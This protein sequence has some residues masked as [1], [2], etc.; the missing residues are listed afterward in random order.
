MLRIRLVV[1]G[2]GRMY[3][4]LLRMLLLR[5]QRIQRRM[6]ILAILNPVQ[7]K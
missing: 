4:L 6:D 2:A 1:S 3:R 5:N 7:Y